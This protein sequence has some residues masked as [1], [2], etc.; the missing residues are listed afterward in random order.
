MQYNIISRDVGVRHCRAPTGVPHVNE[1][2]YKQTWNQ[3]LVQSSLEDLSYT[4]GEFILRRLVET[5]ARS[6]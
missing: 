5:G 1:N 4:P 2:R 6:Q 3:S